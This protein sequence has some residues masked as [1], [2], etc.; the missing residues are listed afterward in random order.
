MQPTSTGEE[1]LSVGENFNLVRFAVIGRNTSSNVRVTECSKRRVKSSIGVVSN[2]ENLTD[3][4]ARPRNTYSNNFSIS[5]HRDVIKIAD[6]A[7]AHLKWYIN[8]IK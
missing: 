7:R 6:S 4:T 8:A 5:L 2:D 1:N 3:C